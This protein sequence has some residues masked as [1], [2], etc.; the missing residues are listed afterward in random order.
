[1]ASQST[2]SIG[3]KIDNGKNGFNELIID[4]NAL[5]KAL[6]STVTESEKL[7]KDLINLSAISTAM[8]S[9]KEAFSELAG[10]IKNVA[11]ESV[12]FSSAM[13]ATNT[14]AGKDEVGL[15]KLKD[16]VTDLAQTVPIARDELAQGLYQVIS[17]GVPEDN[18]IS[19]L[20][21]SSRAAVGG[22]ADL[23]KTVGVT[24]TIIKNYGLSWEKAGEI[25]D[26]IQLT[27]K[28]GVTS[29]EQMAASLPKV[30]G[31]AA[32]LGVSI[33]E[34]MASFATL[35]GVSGN[36]S[37]VATQLGAIFSALVKPSSQAADMAERM[38]IQFNA[39]AIKAAGGFRKFISE[40]K[41]NVQDYAQTSGMLEQEIYSTLFGSAESV[42]ALI[43]LTGELATKFG[44]NVS[45]MQD[46]AGTIDKAFDEMASTSEAKSQLVKNA[47]AG[48]KDMIAN[49]TSWT[50]PY[51]D[52]ADSLT[53]AITNA[54]TLKKAIEKLALATRISSVATGALSLSIKALGIK[55]GSAATLMKVLTHAFKGGTMSAIAL[56]VAIRGLMIATGV[57]VA[58]WALSEAVSYFTGVSEKNKGAIE[59]EADAHNRAA[60]TIEVYKAKIK[61]FTGT[62][63]EEKK[64]I[65]ELNAAYGDSMGQYDTLKGWYD[66]LT[67]KSKEYCAQLK[68]ESRI[69][70]Y[71]DEWAQLDAEK[72]AL[73]KELPNKSKQ[74][75][76][77]ERKS[78][79]ANSYYVTGASRVEVQNSSDYA[80]TERQIKEK[81]EQQ[82]ELER[83]IEKLVKEASVKKVQLSEGETSQKGHPD[84]GSGKSSQTT[85]GKSDQA[86]APKGSI[87]YIKNEISDIEK[88][89]RTSVNS[90]EIYNLE[91][92]KIELQ[93]KL[94]ELE[95]PMR[96][97]SAPQGSIEHIK[98]EI[99]DIERE[100]RFSVDSEKIYNLERKKIELQKTLKELELPVRLA[101]TKEEF[102]DMIG[103]IDPISISVEVD[104]ENLTKDIQEI[105]K[106]LTAT[107]KL[108]QTLGGVSEVAR[109]AGD[110]FRG[111]GQ[112]FEM[113]V[114]DVMGIIAGAI[115]TIVQG[116]ATASAESASLGPFGWAAFSL[117]GLAQLMTMISQIKSATAFADGGV[118]Y[119]PTLG[120]VG[121]YAGA[122]SNPEVIAPLKVAWITI[123]SLVTRA[124][125]PKRRR[126]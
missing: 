92:E 83:K 123:T 113:P 5:R 4:A 41:T 50:L 33:D 13:K 48:I 45:A 87:E 64:L 116:Y 23:G 42:R 60:A 40:L 110:A 101:S 77:V 106:G 115:A 46:S 108:K 62:K 103:K 104:T 81:E 90:E 39:A 21:E 15:E 38:G 102:E 3:F 56:K 126:C 76:T 84:T 28:N 25:Q 71:R 120:L 10:A 35:T 27:A 74:N 67:T 96:L 61:N 73:E 18:W 19:F 94:K 80:V 55:S 114:L 34:L 2:I 29:F 66:T 47:W 49:V 12:E 95:Q 52:F 37:E 119:G 32:T 105:P 7:K 65:G 93:K 122:S 16:Q 112:A 117:T 26:K 111:M 79:S 75:K 82:Q 44:E 58:I 14:M 69:L 63:E 88:K 22:I 17:N 98:N 85:T 1:M 107:E 97:A 100:E 109:S 78:G 89:E 54:I 99:S 121:E 59:S 57:G 72:E 86:T 51:L 53:G 91:R 36:T 31:N 11:G 8:K 30:T 9:S 125:R 24:S 70:R 43:P 6:S 124:Q 68:N 118:V 20:E